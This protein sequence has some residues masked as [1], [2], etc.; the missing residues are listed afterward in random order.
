MLKKKK[1]KD[2]K[3]STGKEEV[4]ETFVEVLCHNVYKFIGRK[5]MYKKKFKDFFYGN[6]YNHRYEGILKKANL[7]LI[8]EE[9]FL[10]IFLSMFL[11]LV[12]ILILSFVYLFINSAIAAIIFYAGIFLVAVSGIF[13][14]N[15]PI[16]TANTRGTE[17][18][19]SIPY[20]LPYMKI[21]AK[22][23]SLSKIVE[24]IGD[25]LIYKEIKTEF[26][27]IKYY[28]SVLGYDVHSS[29]REAMASCP[30]RQLSDMMN[31]LVT[32]SNS[33]GNI[34]NYLERKLENLNQEID[35]VEKK[36]IDTLLIYS[37]IYVV[38][39]LIAPLF[40]TIMSTILNLIDFSSTTGGASSAG[41]NSTV[42]SIFAMLIFLPLVYAAFM[43]LVYYS[44]P[45][46]S[47]LKPIKNETF[48]I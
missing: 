46:Y 47:R 18:D 43:M 24:I 44:K 42:A 31:D 23:L 22:E 1:N 41:G 7:K 16:L 29:I 14:Y 25:F 39:L 20:L 33:G 37:Q 21:L 11:L 5:L 9:Y 6:I 38:I 8:P 35:A 26:Q 30:S 12:S 32:I 10:T 27:K 36:N 15:F 45:L 17:I 2:L 40:Y 48:D 13:L 28:Y 3:K 4:R 19:A 34:Y